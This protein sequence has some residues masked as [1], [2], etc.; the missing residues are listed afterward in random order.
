MEAP[1]RTLLPE[2]L[3][4]V[5]GRRG[6]AFVL[7]LI[8]ELLLALLLLFFLSPKL[9]G[10]DK[11]KTPAIFGFDVSGEKAADKAEA[12]KAKPKPKSDAKAEVKPVTPPPPPPETPPPPPPV[13]TP[14]STLPFIRMTRRDYAAS[15]IAKAP[16]SAPSSSDSSAD[17]AEAG[18][19]GSMPGDS[20]QVGTA[21]NGEP[22]Y[23]AE[24]YRRPTDAQLSPYLSPRARGPGWGLIACRTIARYQVTDCQELG[25]G[26]RG[27]GYAG[28]V[29]QA[30]F[31]FLVRPPRKGGKPMIGSWV[32]IRIDYTQRPK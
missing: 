25:E 7:A 20:E 21:P 32:S 4:T 23:A 11:G 30:A 8:V 6:A 3:R 22:L 2:W 15:D 12:A 18:G 27:S 29:R 9:T 14:N 31:Q 26:P 13:S 16:A 19:G 5:L 28:S 17:V 10:T 24:W 1:P